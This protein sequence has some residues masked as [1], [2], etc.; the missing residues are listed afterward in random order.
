MVSG[1]RKM[2]LIVP[3]QDDEMLI[4]G[5]VLYQFV[6]DKGWETFV[7]Y[8]TEGAALHESPEMRMKEAIAALKV[9]GIS[10]K[11]IIFL[12]YGNEWQGQYN[13]YNAPENLVLTSLR[14]KKQT[15][16][17][18]SHPEYCFCKTGKHHKFARRNYK[19]DL[20]DVILEIK[21][22]VIIAVDVDDHQEH[23]A[24]S[25]F[26]DECLYD[27]IKT[28]N[29]YYPLL[30]KKF[31]YEG[32]WRGKDDYFNI[33]RIPT[34]NGEN[35]GN[36]TRNPSFQWD[37][38]I[39]FEVPKKCNTFFF[40]NNILNKAV[41]KHVSQ[42]GWLCAARLIN[43]DIVYWYR[44][45][46]NLALKANIEVSSG[47]GKFLNDF[48]II[49]TNDVKNK[50]TVWEDCSWF[51]SEYDK[52]SKIFISWQE[53]KAVREIVIYES[54]ELKAGKIMNLYIKLDDG[55]EF[56]TGELKHKA[57]KNIFSLQ[58]EHYIKGME[59]KMMQVE[60]RGGISEIE[61]FS[62]SFNL[63]SYD[64]P[65]KEIGQGDYETDY[66]IIRKVINFFERKLFY[67]KA[68]I[69]LG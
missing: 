54:P 5:S 37:E 55:Y 52:E 63:S 68:R 69:Y 65:M 4:G 42:S 40:C 61:V 44:R 33:P 15:F 21:P 9:I 30:L 67:L 31:A 34:L 18:K 56:Y 3:H 60:G 26:L 16:A 59:I 28:E 58:D 25:L 64:L 38:R 36:I 19:N 17:L 53:E 51:P 29:N 24:T 41:K 57:A 48:K 1:K 11:Q 27:I 12:G 10:E 66:L 62:T 8:T 35:K 7:L 46:D 20:K 32:L 6:Q 47:N 22:E 43:S 49:D 45:T 39:R 50:N 14:G 23:M 2:L 13:I